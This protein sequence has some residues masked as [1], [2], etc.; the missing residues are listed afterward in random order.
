MGDF[1]TLRIESLG[2]PGRVVIVA[3]HPDDEVFALGG[4]MTLF[5]WGGYELEIVAVTDGEASHARSNRITPA[6]LRDLREQET[7]RAYRELG[8]RPQRLRFGLPDSDV[9]SHAEVLRQMLFVR[10]AGASAVFAPIPTDGH[11]DHDSVGQAVAEVAEALGVR[12]WRYAIWARL[13]PERIIQEAGVKIRIP[14][15]VLQRKLRAANQYSSQLDALGPD[16][17]DGPVL[18]EGFL[19]YFTETEEPLWLAP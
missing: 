13:H 3:P 14:P 18:P 12:C 9:V 2:P 8:I 5:E 10:L 16:P 1:Q 15:E 11:P 6:T 19:S 4:T 17:E 7:V